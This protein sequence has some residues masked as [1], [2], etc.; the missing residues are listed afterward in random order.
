[1]RIQYSDLS[2]TTTKLMSAI[3]WAGICSLVGEEPLMTVP[4]PMSG[5]MTY[6]MQT[7]QYYYPNIPIN[8]AE[9]QGK[10]AAF[11]T[12][13]VPKGEEYIFP[14]RDQLQGMVLSAE[15]QHLLGR[16][17]GLTK[18]EGP[19]P[20]LNDVSHAE[21][22][23]QVDRVGGDA[24]TQHL[25]RIILYR[26]IIMVFAPYGF[27]NKSPGKDA[28]QIGSGDWRLFRDH[29]NLESAIHRA[30]LRSATSATVASLSRN[31]RLLLEWHAWR[32]YGDHWDLPYKQ[33]PIV[34]D[35]IA[36][37]ITAFESWLIA[38]CATPVD[39]GL[40]EVRDLH[41]E[42]SARTR[43]KRRVEAL[44]KAWFAFDAAWDREHP[45][46]IPVPVPPRSSTAGSATAAA[47]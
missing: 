30:M 17:N 37:R 18:F 27:N 31:E 42:A 36:R 13:K 32:R 24:I 7:G 3:L 29:D 22:V 21:I 40:Y 15:A 8:D 25:R 4:V 38:D 10:Y 11:S 2:W 1:M 33:I 14:S 34:G 6:G 46:E 44:E 28:P 35:R 47:P 16:I 12:D 39:P 5:D 20:S 26:G 19:P 23:L 43:I 41:P 45:D 9:L